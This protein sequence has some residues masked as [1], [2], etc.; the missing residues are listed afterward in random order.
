MTTPPSVARSR[1]RRAIA[2][3]VGVATVAPPAYLAL[4]I[5]RHARDMPWWDQWGI[6]PLMAE[7]TNGHLPGA[8]LWAQVNEHRIP[9]AMLLQGA[10]AWLTHWDVRGDAWLNLIVSLGTLAALA[11]L[12]RRTVRPVA[13]DAAPW[14]VLIASVLTF[15]PAHGSSWTAG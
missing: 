10:L 12:V 9:A 1:A 13:P 6:V 3:V 2:W 11:A 5:V 15:S 4:L 8:I 7:M 14:L